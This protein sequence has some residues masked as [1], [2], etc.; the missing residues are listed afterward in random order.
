MTRRRPTQ[1][2]RPTRHAHFSGHG[3]PRAPQFTILLALLT[4]TLPG[5]GY[6]HTPL[7]PTTY[8]TVAL[9]IFDNQTFYRGIE[10]E[11]KEALT[12]EIERRTPYKV[13]PQATADSLLVG[14]IV[15]VTQTPLSR[16]ESGGLVQE[17]QFAVEADFEWTDQR[18]GRSIRQRKGLTSV[19]RFI[20]AREIGETFDV[21]QSAAVQ[22]M[23]EAIVSAMAADW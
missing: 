22:R 10:F 19:G 5:C 11:L 14:S 17:L 2:A 15:S 3:S 6:R 20:P 18:D 21:G 13:V 1:P 12:K 16:R 9:P 7:F 4:L 8:R 23:A